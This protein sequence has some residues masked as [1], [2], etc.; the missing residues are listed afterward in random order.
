M[1]KYSVVIV[2]DHTLL[3]QAIASVV[4]GFAMFKVSYLCKNGSELVDKF[5]FEKN[6]PDLVLMDINMPIMNGLE[7]TQ[8]INENHPKVNVLALTIEED[9][10]T[11]LKMLR[12]G[13]KG[14]LLKDVDKK[15]LEMALLKIMD[16]GFYHSSNVTDI[17][18]NSLMGKSKNKIEFK[19]TEIEFLNLVC[20]ELTYKEIA[21]KMSLSPK[22][23]DG[24]R[25]HLFAK[26]NVKNRVGLVLFAI[27]NKIFKP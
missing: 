16:T 18:M 24:Y 4:D 20:S 3:S 14:Y 6:I 2:E 15:T 23:I 22:T 21:D 26:L 7:T 27:K 11:I 13:A 17:L 12:L 5:K 25:D 9:E 8:W 10:N 19:S 1:K